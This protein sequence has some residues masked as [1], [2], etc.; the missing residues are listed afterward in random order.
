V[1]YVHVF[2]STQPVA[3]RKD[4]TP[5]RDFA[6]ANRK[7]RLGMTRRVRSRPARPPNGMDRVPRAKGADAVASMLGGLGWC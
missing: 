6:R 4:A 3:A 7:E 5:S 2:R 1:G